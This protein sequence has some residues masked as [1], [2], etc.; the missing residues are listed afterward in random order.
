MTCEKYIGISRHGDEIFTNTYPRIIDQDLHELIQKRIK[1]NR[2]GKRDPDNIALLKGKVFCGNCGRPMS[3]KTGTNHCGDKYRY[4]KCSGK[5]RRLNDCEQKPIP[6]ERLEKDVLSIALDVIKKEAIEQLAD[7]IVNYR[8]KCSKYTT[9][10]KAYE[11]ERDEKEF[12]LSNLMSALENG[13]STRTTQQRI[14]ELEAR[15]DKLEELISIEK[16]VN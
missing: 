2:Y 11:K 14:L 7:M 6:K 10:L 15:L 16:H 12:A 8:E 9:A 13:I 4:Y 3:I 1:A 5:K